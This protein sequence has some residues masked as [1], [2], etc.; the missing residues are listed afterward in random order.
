MNPILKLIDKVTEDNVMQVIKNIDLN[1]YSLKTALMIPIDEYADRNPD[2]EDMLEAYIDYTAEDELFGVSMAIDSKVWKMFKYLWEDKGA[3]WGEKH[4][5]PVVEVMAEN[6]WDIG[7]YN[8]FKC[9]RTKEIFTAMSCN[10][11]KAFYNKIKKIGEGLIKKKSSASNVFLANMMKG[12]VLK[13]Y[14]TLSF[15]NLFK[16]IH[17]SGTKIHTK[18]I[19]PS[20]CEDDLFIMIYKQNI[21]HDLAEEFDA[22]CSG[23]LNEKKKYRNILTKLIEYSFH[24]M[25]SA[26]PI[27]RIW[28]SIKIGAEDE[29]KR[30][31]QEA[32]RHWPLVITIRKGPT[33]VEF[34][35]V[36]NDDKVKEMEVNKWKPLHLMIYFSRLKMIDEILSYSG[37]SLRKAMTLENKKALITN[38]YFPLMLAIRL[39]KDDI[40]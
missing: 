21:L 25:P 26:I 7:I 4:L 18:D 6:L 40:F 14:T 12:L 3:L 28:K 15:L 11:R 39:K 30:C 33:T 16:C 1:Q 32:K 27:S 17:V 35:Q 29:F 19:E 38:E 37:R 13:P 9:T 24:L 5:I 36:I 23:D 2:K 10:E 34:K 8:L 20:T 22:A 31:I